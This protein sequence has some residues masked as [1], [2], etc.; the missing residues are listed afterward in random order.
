[1]PFGVK[2]FTLIGF[3][4]QA[5]HVGSLQSTQADIYDSSDIN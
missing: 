4:L 5:R 2:R 3:A 1:M